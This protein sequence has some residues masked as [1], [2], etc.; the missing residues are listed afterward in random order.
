MVAAKETDAAVATVTWELDAISALKD[1]CA[2]CRTNRNPGAVAA[3]LLAVQN[4]TG[5]LWM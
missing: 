1:P 3:W 5:P 4:Q 2:T